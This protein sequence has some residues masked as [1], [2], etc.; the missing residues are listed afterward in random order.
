MTDRRYIHGLILDL[1]GTL[2]D[3][4]RQHLAALL[5]TGQRLGIE[6]PRL[7]CALGFATESACL[8]F[9]A[10]GQYAAARVEYQQEFCRDIGRR[11]IR[12]IDGANLALQYLGD[13]RIP[14]GI[15]T[16]RSRVTALA[17]LCRL[18]FEWSAVVTDDDVDSPKPDP[19]GL[20]CA[21]R[22]IGVAPSRCA[23][24]GDTAADLRQG[25]DARIATYLVTH[26]SND[27]ATR[28]DRLV[29]KLCEGRE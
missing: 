3:S 28:L 4:S 26:G 11:G 7:R 6:P 16:G 8:K 24:I 19:E 21:A 5:A 22:Q 15:C 2:V 1:D 13:R 20:L 27:G 23:Y 29:R 12:L 10:G 9:F 25:T 14:V 18:Q 17:I